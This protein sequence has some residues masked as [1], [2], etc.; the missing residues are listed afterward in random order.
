MQA[1]VAG[2]PLGA[3]ALPGLPGPTLG[4]AGPKLDPSAGLGLGWQGDAAGARRGRLPPLP[5]PG[6]PAPRQAGGLFAL[7]LGQ[8]RPASE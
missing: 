7:A 4:V 5:S 6:R 3:P 8:G 2:R 1:L